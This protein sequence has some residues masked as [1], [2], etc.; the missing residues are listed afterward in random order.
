MKK[1]KSL[2]NR[3]L[4][5]VGLLVVCFGCSS[6]ERDVS[7][8]AV[9]DKSPQAP[10][11]TPV[12]LKQDESALLAGVTGA[13][14]YSGYRSGQHPDRGDGAN[15]PTEEQILEDLKILS[16]DSNFKLIRIYD[17]GE[18]SNT[19]LKAIAD[20]GL[21]I[22]V[23]LGIWL[24]AELSTHATCAW[25]SEPIPEETL[26]KNKAKN[27]AEIQRGIELANAYPEIVIA[28]NVGNEA[29]VDW[30]DHRVTVES[31]IGYVNQV[32]DAI[33]QPVTVAENYKWWAE[34][35]QELAKAVDFL[36]VHVYPVWEGK[37]IDEGMSYS[38]ENLSEVRRALPDAPIVISEAGWA[39]AASEFGP[40]ASEANQQRYYDELMSWSAENNM[41]TFFF[42]AFDEDWKG[43]PDSPMGAEKHWG[44]FTIDR[45]PKQVMKQLY[46][47]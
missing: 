41:T 29:L 8:W 31:V 21:D 16:R 27:Q 1:S 43:D 34:N 4:F 14:G 15:N 39:S 11:P 40:R 46:P 20:N 5:A 2:A 18:N 12:D 47:E 25:L 6:E 22:K 26:A 17:S 10:A 7:D 36:S 9:K 23:M 28:V 30:N 19:V 38:L 32:K 33:E 24:D 3:T 42:E 44:I 37:G 35:G 13:I 45:K